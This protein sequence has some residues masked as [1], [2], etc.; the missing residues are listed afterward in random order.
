MDSKPRL[1]WT[2]WLLLAGV[3]ATGCTKKDN[4]TGNNWSGIDL[5]RNRYADYRLW[6]QLP[7][8]RAVKIKGTE[9]KLLAAN[10]RSA[11]SISY[12]RFTGLP[13]SGR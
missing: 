2:L 7:C 6:L 13:A 9:A 8:R 4:L 3:I 11:T 1:K 12:L 10:E 5:K